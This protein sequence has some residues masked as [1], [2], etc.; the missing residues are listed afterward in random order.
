MDEEGGDGF[1]GGD[2]MGSYSPGGGQ[3]ETLSLS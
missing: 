1:G 2:G 3:A